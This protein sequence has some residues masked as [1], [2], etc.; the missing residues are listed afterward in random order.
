MG[1]RAE[2]TRVCRGACGLAVGVGVGVSV[3]NACAAV[4]VFVRLYLCL[5]K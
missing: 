5:I 2:C 4:R 3:Y 1:P